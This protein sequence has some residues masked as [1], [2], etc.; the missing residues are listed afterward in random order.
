[1]W[2]TLW[3]VTL[4]GGCGLVLG[5]YGH[6]SRTIGWHES[7]ERQVRFVPP[8]SVALTPAQQVTAWFF[9][10]VAAIFLLQNLVGGATVHY[11]VEASGFLGIDLPTWLPYN[12]TWTWHLQMAIFFLATAYLAAGIFLTL[13]IAGREPRGQGMLS[14]VLLGA[15]AMVVFGSLGGEYLSYHNLLPRGQ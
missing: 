3:L 8:A 9:L 10:L 4:L 11:M 14:V 5:L 13:L 15:L 6:Y 12:L 7:E 2:S 1:M